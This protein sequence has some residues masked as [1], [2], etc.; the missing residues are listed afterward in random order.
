MQHREALRRVS[1]RPLP[2]LRHD[3]LREPVLQLEAVQRV[4]V[5]DVRGVE[6]VPQ[7]AHAHAP[8]GVQRALALALLGGRRRLLQGA[9]QRRRRGR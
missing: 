2:P 9:R 1:Q 3:V 7:L 8:H 4:A 5:L 6:R